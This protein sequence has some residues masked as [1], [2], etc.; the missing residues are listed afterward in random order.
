[1]QAG[2]LFFEP[3]NYK[4]IYSLSK[5]RLAA[6]IYK[7]QASRPPLERDPVTNMILPHGGRSFIAELQ[8]MEGFIEEK[9]NIAPIVYS[10]EEIVNSKSLPG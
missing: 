2:G 7:D 6:D 4:L 3:K 10:A 8:A 9:K 1:M 5:L